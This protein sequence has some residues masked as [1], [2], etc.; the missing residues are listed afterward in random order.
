MSRKDKAPSAW[1]KPLVS[2][3][4][5]L[6]LLGVH[7]GAATPDTGWNPYNPAFREYYGGT[8]LFWSWEIVRSGD[9][10]IACH[11]FPPQGEPR[12]TVFLVHGFLEHTAITVPA[13]RILVEAGWE[14]VG[15]DLPGHGL[16]S[17]PR[18]AI[19]DFASYGRAV[20]AVENSN[21]WP[22]PWRGYGHSTGCSALIEAESLAPGR[23]EALFFEAPLVRSWGWNASV[24]GYTLLGW[25]KPSLPARGGASSRDPSFVRF[26]EKDPL[27]PQNFPLSWFKALRNFQRA[28]KEV[29][30]FDSPLT[31]IQGSA[32]TVV[33]AAYNLPLLESIFTKHSVHMIPGAYHYL[34]RDPEA[35]MAASIL[36][37]WA[38]EGATPNR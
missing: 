14:V 37:A 30:P 33:D 15:I 12:G 11:V 17:G 24:C 38:S 21:A 34:F 32:D 31:I 4:S 5:L 8:G 26:L 35:P 3:I 2:A 6:A 28:V 7:A 22:L 9:Y 20:L 18:A 10:E 27:R 13:V 29:G 23:L 16:S 25:L 36:A 1:T 19:D